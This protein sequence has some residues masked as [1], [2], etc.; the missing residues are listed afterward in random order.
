MSDSN[1]WNEE[2]KKGINLESKDAVLDEAIMKSTFWHGDIWIEVWR[3]EQDDGDSWSEVMA[4]LLKLWG[5]MV[6]E[7]QWGQ[8][9]SAADCPRGGEDDASGG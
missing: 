7:K 4:V 8:R 3:W 5:E 9:T 1:R 6:S 2:N